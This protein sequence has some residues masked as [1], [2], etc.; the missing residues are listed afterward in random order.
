M[1]INV[2]F[3]SRQAKRQ[4]ERRRAMVAAVRRGQSLH[5]VARQFGFGVATVAH[6][7][8]RA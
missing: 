1:A 6:S 7:V 8:E 4:A 2:T 5:A 3:L